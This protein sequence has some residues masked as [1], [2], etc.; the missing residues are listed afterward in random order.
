[1]DF[2]LTLLFSHWF[3]C[4]NFVRRYKINIIGTVWTVCKL[5]PQITKCS[6]CNKSWKMSQFLLSQP[7]TSYHQGVLDFSFAI[8]SSCWLPNSCQH[9][10]LKDIAGYS[11]TFNGNSRNKSDEPRERGS[12]QSKISQIPDK[13][14]IPD[15][16][17]K[18]NSRLP[19]RQIS[20]PMSSLR[21]QF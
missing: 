3:V 19:W 20:F 13:Y 18:R 4:L 14:Q 15:T 2:L 6:V 12:N 5:W 8:K 10:K 21:L 17:E 11:A 1:M 7:F 16:C 9:K